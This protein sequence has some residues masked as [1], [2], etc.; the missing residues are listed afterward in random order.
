MT[1]PIMSTPMSDKKRKTNCL[2][3]G[4]KRKPSHCG[5]CDACYLKQWRMV[6]KGLVSWHDL[7]RAGLRLKPKQGSKFIRVTLELVKRNGGR[8]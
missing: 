1:L 8:K 7:E 5:V 2:T 6:R 4:C 3:K